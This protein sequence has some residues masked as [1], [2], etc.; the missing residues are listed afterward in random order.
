MECDEL[1]DIDIADTITVG[2]A[3]RLL[4]DY[5]A[6]ALHAAS[7]HRLGPRIENRHA[8]WF[9]FGSTPYDLTIRHVDREIRRIHSVI[10]KILSDELDTVATEYDE[11][12]ET[13]MSVALHDVPDDRA[14]TDFHH[15]LWPYCGFF[16]E[17]CS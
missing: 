4:A 1:A 7:R 12:R 13:I 6:G 5:V 3:E 2:Q 11:I 9:A 17:P 8:P 16:T 14:P 15:R 10:Q